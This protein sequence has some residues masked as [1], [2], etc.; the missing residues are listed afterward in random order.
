MDNHTFF[1]AAI[2]SIHDACDNFDSVWQ[3]R[4]RKVSTWTI[5]RFLAALGGASGQRE[6]L[7]AFDFQKKVYPPALLFLEQG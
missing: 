7:A 5:F 6:A 2:K 3:I 1:T 4:S